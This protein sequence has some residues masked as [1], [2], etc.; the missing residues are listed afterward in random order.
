MKK[1]DT[2]IHT[3]LHWFNKMGWTPFQFQL[4]TWRTYLNGQNGLVNAPTGSGKTYSLAVPILLEGLQNKDTLPSI[5]DFKKFSLSFEVLN[6]FEVCVITVVWLLYCVFWFFLIEGYLHIWTS[7]T[8]SFTH[9]TSPLE[10]V[11]FSF[12]FYRFSSIRMKF[13]QSNWNDYRYVLCL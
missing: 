12:C 2:V 10:S 4:D 7:L 5:A 6:S 1:I 9:S 8:S 3:A 13:C 11:F